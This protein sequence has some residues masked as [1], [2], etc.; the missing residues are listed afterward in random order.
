MLT[1][2][3]DEALLNFLKVLNGDFE[4]ID[5][6]ICLVFVSWVI[7]FLSVLSKKVIVDG[8]N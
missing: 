4:S 2:L 5:I 1:F 7:A 6:G 8:I 3:F